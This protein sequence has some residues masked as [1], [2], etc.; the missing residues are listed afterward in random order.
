MMGLKM[1]ELKCCTTGCQWPSEEL[2]IIF[3][4]AI[5]TAK[6]FDIVAPYVDLSLVVLK[7]CNAGLLLLVRE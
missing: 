3:S 5:I 1:T 6:M 2:I 4:P 7:G